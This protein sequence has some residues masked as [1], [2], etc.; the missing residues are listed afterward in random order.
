VTDNLYDSWRVCYSAV[1]ATLARQLRI[2]E[3]LRWL[4][5]RVK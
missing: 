2:H 5:R 4:L 3:L 1:I